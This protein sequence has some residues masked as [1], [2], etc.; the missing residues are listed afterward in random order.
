[1]VKTPG[2]RDVFGGSKCCSRGRR[3]DFDTLQNT[4]QAQEFVR[5]AKTLAGV[6]D[7]NRVRNDGFRVA[8]AWISWFL[9]C[10]CLKS[11][12][13]NP[14]KAFKCHITEMLLCRNHFAWQLQEFVCIGS[15]FSW[16]AQYFWRIQRS[17]QRPGA[18]SEFIDRA[19]LVCCHKTR[20]K[21]TA[22]LFPGPWTKTFQSE[23]AAAGTNRP[24]HHGG[25][26]ARYSLGHLRPSDADHYCAMRCQRL[27]FS[28]ALTSAAQPLGEF[29]TRQWVALGRGGLLHVLLRG[30]SQHGK[31]D[32]H[33]LWTSLQIYAMHRVIHTKGGGETRVRS[34]WRRAIADRPSTSQGAT[35]APATYGWML[36]PAQKR[37]ET[38]VLND[39]MRLPCVLAF[40][41]RLPWPS[42]WLS[43]RPTS[44][45]R[46]DVVPSGP[47][48][49]PS[50][51][52]A[53]GLSGAADDVTTL[54]SF[55]VVVVVR[56]SRRPS[57]P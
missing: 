29:E 22:T 24:L 44:S 15:T 50:S 30:F 16:Q 4:Q 41:R 31:R 45:C 49:R 46:H 43:R 8:G 23:M 34:S 35:A 6:V 1:M 7:L 55:V 36:L 47:S 52:L 25:M 12:T 14:W 18:R 26:L 3:R 39:V 56:P 17:Q 27:L 51:W 11:R 2:A 20:H 10:R 9:W 54:T 33:M 37:V 5:D 28:I 57:G 40:I 21:A 32:H 38:V 19:L 53:S 48:G 42:S 13:L